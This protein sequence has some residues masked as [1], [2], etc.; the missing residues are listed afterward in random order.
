MFL[1]LLLISA[2]SAMQ[3]PPRTGDI[4]FRVKSMASIT[5]SSAI[6]GERLIRPDWQRVPTAGDFTRID[7]KSLVHEAVMQA[8]C[9]PAANGK[10]SGCTI[11][12]MY[13]KRPEVRRMFN[14]ALGK[15]VLSPA[16]R[17]ALYGK[18]NFMTVSLL[19]SNP[20]G[21]ESDISYCAPFFCTITPPPPRPQPRK[22]EAK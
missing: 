14:R 1:S 7:R 13:P 6:R 19:M 17:E 4:K 20:G 3:T 21:T 18:T 11:G 22:V 12:E 9:K 16:S 5:D 8:V 2:V 10:L 15:L